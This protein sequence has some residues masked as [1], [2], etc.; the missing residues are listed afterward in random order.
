MYVVYEE[1]ERESKGKQAGV[2]YCH[3]PCTPFLHSSVE[4]VSK[5]SNHRVALDLPP[6]RF[7]R[8]VLVDWVLGASTANSQVDPHS[9]LVPLL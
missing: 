3:P 8:L 6:L 7:G 2:K 1:A 5:S 4:E 9:P